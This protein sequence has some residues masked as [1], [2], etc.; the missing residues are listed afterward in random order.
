MYQVYWTHQGRFAVEVDANPRYRRLLTLADNGVVDV[1]KRTEDQMARDGYRPYAGEYAAYHYVFT[2][3]KSTLAKTVQAETAMRRVMEDLKD[4]PYADLCQN[5][6]AIDRSLGSEKFRS[7]QALLRSVDRALQFVNVVQPPKESTTMTDT[8]SAA[9]ATFGSKPEA[10]PAAKKATK[11]VAAPAVKKVEPVKPAAKKAAKTMEPKAAKKANTAPATAAKKA[12]ATAKAKAGAFTP[13][14]IDKAKKVCAGT[15]GSGALI[16]ELLKAGK[17]DAEAIVS[18]VLK[19]F[20]ERKT[21][22][23]DVSWNKSMM[24]KAGVIKA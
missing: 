9:P 1:V 21:S 18:A 3:A 19:K 16:R 8:T 22:A 5:L 17:L 12:N 14:Q 15:I 23:S 24:I 7:K 4:K 20:P 13:E 10:K 11:K 2:F 6:G